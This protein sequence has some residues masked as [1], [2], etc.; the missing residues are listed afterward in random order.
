LA[1]RLSALLKCATNYSIKNKKLF[2]YIRFGNF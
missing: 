2:N 1:W